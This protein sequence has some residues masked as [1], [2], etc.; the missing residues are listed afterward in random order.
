MSWFAWAALCSAVA[1]LDGEGLAFGREP[2]NAPPA[3]AGQFTLVANGKP[4]S[5]IVTGESAPETVRFAAKE[6]RTFVAKMSGA[7]LPINARP[8]PGLPAIRLGPAAREVL[9]PEMLTGVRRDGYLI[10]IAGGDLCIV[11]LDDAGP[12]TDIEALLAAGKTH[13]VPLW[14]F[15]RGTL[16][17][18]YRL[19]ESLGMRWFMPGEFG[20][21]VKHAP[22]L[23]FSGEIRENP[24][25]ISRT[26]GYWSLWTG[27]YYQ[28]DYKRLTVMPG[29]RAA[30][31]FTPAENRMWELRMRGATFQIPL[32]HYPTSTRWVERFGREHPEYFA[33]YPSGKRS[34]VDRQEDGH[35]CYSEPGV[36]RETV[37]D[38]QAFL[39]GKPSET[40]GISRIHPITKRPTNEDNRGWPEHIAYGGY[41]SLLP[42]DGFRACQCERCKAL[43]VD[44]KGGENS[45]QVWPYVARCAT[46][47]PE[48]KVT[49]LAYGSY[50]RPYSG[51]ERLPPNVVVGF[52]TF[53]HPASLYYGDTF[54]QYESLVR[55][56]AA[57]THGNMAFW[58]HY[59]ASNRDEENVGIPE[60]TPEMYARVVRV[61]AQHGN[62]V[63]CEMM[64]DSIM[65]ELFNRYLLVRLFYDPTLDEAALFH[66]YALR[67]Y[68][69]EAGPLVAEIYADLNTKCIG[70]FRYRAAAFSIWE[71][72]FSAATMRGYQQKIE[73]AAKLTANT[74]YASAVTAFKDYYLGLMERGRARYADPLGQ[75]LAAGKPELVPR[76]A[77]LQKLIADLPAPKGARPTAGL[78]EGKTV[79]DWSLSSTDFEADLQA[80]ATLCKAG[81]HAEAIDAW[82]RLGASRNDPEQR[83]QAI[84]SAAECV[85]LH[86]GGEAKALE[87]CR[88]VNAEPYIKAARARVYQWTSSP[89]LVLADLGDEDLSAWPEE[90]AAKAYAVRGAAH[91]RLQHGPEAARDYLRAFQFAKTYHKW[92][93]F[94]RL[95]DTC[96][97]LLDDP[98]LAEACY[99]KCM[100]DFGGGW[101]GLEA[102]LRLGELLC[103]QN[104]YDDAAACLDMPA[105]EGVWGASMLIG[106]AKVHMAAGRKPEARAAVNTALATP[107]VMAHQRKECAALLEGLK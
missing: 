2:Q 68:G 38:I 10:T 96:W 30:I 59:L 28:K 34:N 14:D 75:L 93:A 85:R 60:H 46:Q 37:A 90:L 76:L 100:A 63:F 81:K 55:Q 8:A 65:F 17:G 99:R 12:R 72:L 50:S 83:Y 77:R 70:R 61:M 82:L 19:L 9:A 87:L 16:Y 21:R 22:T 71:R 89:K 24:H 18:V 57:L 7:E 5:Q 3:A 31:G 45:R 64:A 15:H 23:Q 66:D 32:N 105:L 51:M 49:C 69:P 56:W 104:R 67:F 29:E 102:R 88:Q 106:K 13:S 94:Q 53:S 78:V 80:A 27:A 4:T 74:E 6:L 52:C 35:L 20:Q 58:Q 79:Q 40:R 26:V 48:A 1:A 62:H 33:L 98:L 11:G 54:E 103:E 97:K 39:A 42:H 36:V 92:S 44:V 84:S 41:F 91:F 43:T 73:H 25:F 101:P 95:G 86:A 47:V 107:G